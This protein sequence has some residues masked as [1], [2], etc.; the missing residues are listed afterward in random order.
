MLRRRRWAWQL[1]VCVLIPTV[2]FADTRAE[3]RRHFKVGMQLISDGKVDDGIGELL[4]AYSIRPHP[5]VLFNIAKAYETAQ[6]P[7]DAITFYNRYLETKPPDEEQVRA[8]VAKLTSQLPK[9][10]PKPEPTK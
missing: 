3:A 8:V 9:V 7:A 5:N 2:A 1:A 4:E 6:R 10:E